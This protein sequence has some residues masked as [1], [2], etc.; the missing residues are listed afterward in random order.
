MLLPAWWTRKGTKLRLAARAV[1]KT[2]KMHG[3][4]GT[5]AR[6][7]PQVRLG[8]RAGRPEAHAAAS[9]R[10]WPGSRRRWSRC[11][12]SGCSSAPRRS[13]R[14]STSG[15]RRAEAAITA[16]EV[17]QM[18]LGVARPPGGLAFEGVEADGLGRRPARPARGAGGVRGAR[19]RRA[20]F[21][22]TLAALPGARLLLARLPAPLG[23]RRL[24]GRRHGAGQ[25]RP[26]ARPDPAR[27]G[28][29]RQARRPT[30]LI[31]PMSVVGNWQKEAGAVH[32]RP[33]RD[34]PPRPDR[35][36][37]G[38]AFKKQA[39]QHALVLSSYALLHRD[40]DAVRARCPGPA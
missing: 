1:V 35:G 14:P 7:D 10:R 2:P 18:A 36:P 37:R 30:L 26:D 28:G 23:P 16:R 32:A 24:P 33:A 21:H 20:G 5:V 13:R 27:L 31:C 17:V 22:G 12:A 9:W 40:F 3:G 8:G 6:G 19:R 38:R 39:A 15:R 34:G 4:S 11:A 29:E 25:D